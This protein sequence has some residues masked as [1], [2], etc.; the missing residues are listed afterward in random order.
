MDNHV[1][2][3]AN[4]TFAHTSK[5]TKVYECALCSSAGQTRKT[6][7]PFIA[8]CCRFLGENDIAFI[9]DEAFGHTPALETL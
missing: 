8:V 7:G 9:G 1:E 6:D 3:I 4:G 2:A 5:L